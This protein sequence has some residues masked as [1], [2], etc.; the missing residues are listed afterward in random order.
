MYYLHI[1]KSGVQFLSLVLKICPAASINRQS[2]KRIRSF[3]VLCGGSCVCLST[4]KA[5]VLVTFYCSKLE[6]TETIIPALNGLTTLA[7]LST[8][9]SVEVELITRA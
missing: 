4:R 8:C 7:S 2:S 9:T 6:D 5:Q 3:Y 1:L